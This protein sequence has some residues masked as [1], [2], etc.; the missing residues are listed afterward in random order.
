MHL[1]EPHEHLPFP[2]LPRAYALTQFF[3]GAAHPVSERECESP[4]R[5]RP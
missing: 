1:L 5:M 4:V 3:Y 2:E